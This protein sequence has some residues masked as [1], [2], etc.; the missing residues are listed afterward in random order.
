V[1]R[2]IAGERSV[3]SCL[4]AL[5][6]LLATSAAVVLRSPTRAESEP[7]G[8]LSPTQ[9]WVNARLGQ[10]RGSGSGNGPRS[11]WALR[12]ERLQENAIGC[13][14]VPLGNAAAL[15]PWFG[16]DGN[17]VVVRVVQVD[18]RTGA[19]VGLPGSGC[20][21]PQDLVQIP[22]QAEV[23]QALEH[24]GIPQPI[25]TTSPANRGLTGLETW[26]WFDTSGHLQVGL[27]LRGFT[28]TATADAKF[29]WST[30]DGAVFETGL[31]G[32]GQNPAVRHVYDSKSP[33]TGYT[34]TLDMIWAGGYN[35][36]GFGDAGAG[37]LGPV[38]RRGTRSYPV[39]EVRSVLQ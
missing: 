6:V 39:N 35:W 33:G 8:G 10:P 23:F 25:V 9:L 20:L 3:T 22:G 16:K 26:Y 2:R 30:G 13:V 37:Q 17:P 36:F 14:V 29:H 7:G 38:T 31:G 24:Q 1:T 11:G 12:Y 18:R 4:L 5:S 32:T 21:D 27:N 19:E 28:V 34:V 15:R